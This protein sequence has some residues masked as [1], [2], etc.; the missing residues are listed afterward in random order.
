MKARKQRN[1]VFCGENVKGEVNPRDLYVE[2]QQGTVRETEAVA[3]P[4]T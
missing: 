1:A 2:P 3:P 4:K